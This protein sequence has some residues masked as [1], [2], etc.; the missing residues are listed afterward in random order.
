MQGSVITG[1]DHLLDNWRGG[2]SAWPAGE[3]ITTGIVLPMDDDVPAGEYQLEIGL[4]D[5][6][7][8]FM[9]SGRNR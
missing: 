8:H 7:T 5:L 6:A 3:S 2:S 4:Y 9:I 1:H